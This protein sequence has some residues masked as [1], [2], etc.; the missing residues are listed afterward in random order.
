MYGLLQRNVYLCLKYQ[1]TILYLPLT[2]L[3]AQSIVY[4]IYYCCCCCCKLTYNVSLFYQVITP[5]RNLVL[6]ADSRKEMEEWIT[7]LR[8]AA[9][10]EFY[11]VCV[12]CC[13]FLSNFSMFVL[14]RK[15]NYK[16][17]PTYYIIYM[18]VRGCI[19]FQHHPSQLI[20]DIFP[21][22]AESGSQRAVIW[23]SQLV[24]LL[25]CTTNLLQRLS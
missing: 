3:I 7:A 17:I 9:S 5:F 23:I 21:I 15:L 18:Y 1:R 6:C 4:S 2:I 13:L 16:I 10:R 24:C 25:P 14:N 12:N 20:S 19:S 22:L 8:S 11:D